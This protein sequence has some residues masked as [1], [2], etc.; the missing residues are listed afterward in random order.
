[1]RALANPLMVPLL[2]AALQ[3]AARFWA[4]LVPKAPLSAWLSGHGEEYQGSV[5]SLAVPCR[6]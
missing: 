6:F 2:R 5:A 3:H 1:M 4:S